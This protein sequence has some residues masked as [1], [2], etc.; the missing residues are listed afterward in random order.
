MNGNTF[1][2]LQ[3]LQ[4]DDYVSS[5]SSESDASDFS[6]DISVRTVSLSANSTSSTNSLNS[7]APSPAQRPRQSDVL[8]ITWHDSDLSPALHPF[9]G[10]PGVK[11]NIDGDTSALDVFLNFFLQH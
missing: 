4:V 1:T 9:T 2:P 6:D 11:A 8:S 5:G 10:S 3:T 7:D